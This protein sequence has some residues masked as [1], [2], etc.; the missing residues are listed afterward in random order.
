MSESVPKFLAKIDLFEGLSPDV[1]SDLVSRGTTLSKPAGATLVEQGSADA[2]LQIVLEGS[3]D[4]SVSGVARPSLSPGDYFGEVSL[5][6]GLPRSATIVAGPDGVTTFALSALSFAPVMR[7][8]PDVAQA[9][10]KA[11]CARLRSLEAS[12]AEG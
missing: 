3:A 4:V 9:L 5:I 8:N 1:L 2:G 10:L 6:D 7:E 12:S 11:L